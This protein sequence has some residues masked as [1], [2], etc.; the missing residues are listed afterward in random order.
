MSFKYERLRNFC[1]CCGMLTHDKRDCLLN[2]D[3]G[4]GPPGP[5]GD[6]DPDSDAEE[7]IQAPDG[8]NI[9]VMTVAPAA[10]T[11]APILLAP[12]QDAPVDNTNAVVESVPD[13]FVDTDLQAEAMRYQAKRFAK[14]NFREDE[15]TDVFEAYAQHQVGLNKRK[16]QEIEEMLRS[17]ILVIDRMALSPVKKKERCEESQDS[18]S[19]NQDID[20]GA[21]DPVPP[22]IA[23]KI[24]SWNCQG[25][26]GSLTEPRLKE[27]CLVVSPDIFFLIETKNKSDVVRD[28]AMSLGY[29]NVLCVPPVGRSGGLA[30][31]S[32]K[33]VSI[34]SIYED[35]RLI[36]VFVKYNGMEFYLSCVY[37]HPVQ[38]YRHEL[39]ERL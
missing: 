16:R 14:G 13:V 10:I 36:D 17:P 1:Q 21:E 32:K 19:V 39:W 23:M 3:N 29:A 6:D 18:C 15:F 2:F 33:E 9:A 37:R 34:S 28:L 11:P 25:L 12:I 31:L 35:V 22:T 7:K 24:C 27:L 4:E 30:L 20:G 38:Q 8:D 5:D 26:G